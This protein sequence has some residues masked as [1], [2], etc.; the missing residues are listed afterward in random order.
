MCVNDAHNAHFDAEIWFQCVI[1]T[2]TYLSMS[3]ILEEVLITAF[4]S[5]GCLR[6]CFRAKKNDDKSFV[7]GEILLMDNDRSH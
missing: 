3:A 1:V 4:F 5:L 7:F 6:F 2:H